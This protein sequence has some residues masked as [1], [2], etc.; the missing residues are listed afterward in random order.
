MTSPITIG[1]SIEPGRQYLL[2]SAHDG[3]V[4]TLVPVSIDADG[5]VIADLTTHPEAA[6]SET[7]SA[8]RRLASSAEGLAFAAMQEDEDCLQSYGL[9]I[10]AGEAGTPAQL[11]RELSGLYI[12]PAMTRIS[13]RVR[14]GGG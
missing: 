13:F 9:A 5:N 14:M 1:A 11:G 10:V 4:G 7:V 6:E 3:P 8:M 2:F 12:N